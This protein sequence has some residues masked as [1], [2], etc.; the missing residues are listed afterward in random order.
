[1]ISL[2]GVEPQNHVVN[3][4]RTKDFQPLQLQSTKQQF[5]VFTPKGQRVFLLKNASKQPQKVSKKSTNILC[6]QHL[7]QK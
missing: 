6:L 5:V 2:G 4:F 3:R 7:A 1:M